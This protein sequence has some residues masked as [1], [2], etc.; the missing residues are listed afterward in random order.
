MTIHALILAGGRGERL[1]QVRKA[2]LRFGGMTLLE[3][4]ASIMRQAGSPLLVASGPGPAPAWPQGM[5]LPD[6][7]HFHL[8]PMAGIAA[9]AAHLRPTAGADDILVSVAVDT[10][11]LPTDFCPRLVAALEQADAAFAAWGDDFYPTN[12]AWRIPALV[13]LLEQAKPDSP[14][15]ALRQLGAIP[16]TWTEPANPFANLNTPADL[17][18]LARRAGAR[19]E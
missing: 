15:Q 18:A 8:G 19:P 13:A 14:R 2:L 7:E 3:R 11:F 17:V 1:G 12:A 5:C 4:T 6:A 16:V 9:A 10:P